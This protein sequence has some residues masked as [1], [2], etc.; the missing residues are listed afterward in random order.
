MASNMIQ[1]AKTDRL[2]NGKKRYMYIDRI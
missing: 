2:Y 1:A